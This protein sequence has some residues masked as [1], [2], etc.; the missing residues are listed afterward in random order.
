MIFFEILTFI[1]KIEFR[2]VTQ[3]IYFNERKSW[4][5]VNKYDVS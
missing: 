1:L 5:F 3:Q 4:K 2:K